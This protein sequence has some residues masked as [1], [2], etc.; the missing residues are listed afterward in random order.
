[1]GGGGEGGG[2]GQGGRA[3]C[4]VQAGSVHK[5]CLGVR[6]GDTEAVRSGDTELLGVRSEDTEA[7][8]SEEWRYRSC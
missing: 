4:H 2:G 3:R 7:V 1:M 6:S 8:R 5:S